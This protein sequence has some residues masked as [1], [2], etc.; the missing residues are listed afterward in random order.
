MSWVLVNRN[1]NKTQHTNACVVTK[2]KW[3]AKC[4][5]RKCRS[6]VKTNIFVSVVWLPSWCSALTLSQNVRLHISIVI[7]AGPNKS[8]RRLENLGHHVVNKPVLIPDLQLVKLWLVIPREMLMVM[9]VFFSFRQKSILVQW[10]E[11]VR[12]GSLFKQVVG[13]VALVSKIKMC[14][15]RLLHSI[16]NK[17]TM[18]LSVVCMVVLKLV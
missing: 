4:N 2:R 10:D 15:Q 17:L 13:A 3:N 8:S 7:L 12:T 11:L 9:P 16:D 18:L 14:L 6:A 5:N 1:L